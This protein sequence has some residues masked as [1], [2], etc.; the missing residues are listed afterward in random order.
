[1]L[2]YLKSNLAMSAAAR[3]V[4]SG[5]KFARSC[6]FGWALPNFLLWLFHKKTD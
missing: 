6:D 1:M 4:L 2:R 3:R 5:A